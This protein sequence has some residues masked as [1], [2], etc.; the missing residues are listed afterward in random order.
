MKLWLKI[1]LVII[2]IIL[3][4]VGKMLVN[5]GFFTEIKPHFN[6]TVTKIDGFNGAEDIVVDRQTGLA[7]IAATNFTSPENG[8]IFL[9]NLKAENPKPI[10]LTKT[11]PFKSFH[12]HGISFYQSPNGTKKLFVVNHRDE[13]QFIEI[14]QFTDSTLVH[15]ESITNTLFISPNDIVAVGERAFYLT[16]DHD[17]PFSDWRS[18]KDLLQI[19]MGNVCYF[20]GKNAQIMAKGILYAN[21]INKSLDGTKIFVASASGQKIKIF[22]RNI[23]SEK[24]TETDEIAINGPDNIDVDEEGNLWVG[25]H[26]KLLAYV[27]HSKDHSKLSPSEIIKIAYKGKGSAHL[28]S[29][30]LTDG[31]EISGSTVGVIFDDKLLIGSVF[32]KHVLLNTLKK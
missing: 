29:I 9:L 8:A 32:E 5:A 7:L 15:L 14:F 24:L 23:K 30:Y 16:N 12:P 21:G 13:G 26:P 25:C 4:F 22:D 20:D 1:L 3:F 31:S 2:A 10:N 28:E 17:E 27:A 18:K 11:L 6:G 19:P